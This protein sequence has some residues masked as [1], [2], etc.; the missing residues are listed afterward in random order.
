ML[1]GCFRARFVHEK[2][3]YDFKVIYVAVEKGL[4]V[5]LWSLCSHRILKISRYIV[6]PVPQRSNLKAPFMFGTL[7]QKQSLH[8]TIGHSIDEV[9]YNNVYFCILSE[10]CM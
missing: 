5:V 3:L 9:T 8:L 6:C 2:K 7:C 10:I 4:V 1:T